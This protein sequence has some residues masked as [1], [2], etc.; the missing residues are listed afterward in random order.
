M[1]R[2]G[3]ILALLFMAVPVW[4]VKKVTVADLTEMLKSLQQ[5]K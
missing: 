5:Q 2:F 4:P 1:K 3:C